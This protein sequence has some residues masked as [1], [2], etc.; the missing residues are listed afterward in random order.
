MGKFALRNV[1]AQ[2]H[3]RTFVD[4]TIHGI[5][6]SVSNPGYKHQGWLFDIYILA[7]VYPIMQLVF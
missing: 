3:K 7:M 5:S 1:G 2:L 6:S 4:F